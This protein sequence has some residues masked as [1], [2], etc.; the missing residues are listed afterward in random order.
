MPTAKKNTTTG[1]KKAPVRSKKPAPKKEVIAK[2]VEEVIEEE[3]LVEEDDATPPPPPPK[4]NTA[5]TKES[6]LA[7]FDEL[8]KSCDDEITTI[9][10]G[11]GKT[12]GTQFLRSLNAK[13]KKLQKQTARVAK[14]KKVRKIGEQSN[15]GFL[16]PVKVTDEMSNFAGWNA[17]ELHSRVDV[18]KFICNY[19]K[20]NDL[21]NPA[22]R[23][24]IVPDTKLKKLFGLKANDKEPIPYFQIQK[25]LKGHFPKAEVTA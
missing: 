9:R 20:E 10:S 4:R 24:K 16:K 7:L 2:I 17:G 12:K 18:T 22:D 8:I 14:G 3:T 13:L 25:L 1:A 11:D 21:Q 5:P 23:R 6:V 19:V 15:S